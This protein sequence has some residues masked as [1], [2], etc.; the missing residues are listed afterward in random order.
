MQSPETVNNFETPSSKPNIIPETSTTKNQNNIQIFCKDLSKINDLDECGWTPLYRSIISGDAS[1]TLFLLNNGADPNIKCTMGETPLYQAVEMEKIDHIKL[2]LKKGADPNITNDDDISPLHIAVNK[3]NIS[4]VKI[5]LKYG[6]NPNIKSKLYQQTPLHLAIKNNADPIFLLLLV[7]F[8]GSLLKE[9]KFNKKPVDYTNSKEMQNTIE[10]LKFGKEEQKIEK[11]K[12]V[13]K[14]E[15][16]SKKN[17]LTLNNIYSNTIR[18]QS[19][20]KELII[21]NNNA[22]LQNPGN[23]KLTII[24]GKNNIFSN[25]KNE[26]STSNNNKPK[27]TIKKELFNL[28]EENIKNIQGTKNENKII[29]EENKENIDKN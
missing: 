29:T 2:L 18:S 22:I 9:D 15:T 14:F 12:E 20:G 23:V 8:N 24:D 26:I 27:E 6:A 16:P 4:I 19:K 21:S 25:D 3:Q 13:E 7:Q 5:L 1:S 10:K 17:E 11:I 28:N